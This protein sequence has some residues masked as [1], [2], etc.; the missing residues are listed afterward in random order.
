MWDLNFTWRQYETQGF[1][2]VTTFNLVCRNQAPKNG[3]PSISIHKIAVFTEDAG[4]NFAQTL[5]KYVKI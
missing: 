5:N 4:N 2:D 1:Q 3:F